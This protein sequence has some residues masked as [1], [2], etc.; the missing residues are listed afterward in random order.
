M[1][2][3]IVLNYYLEQYQTLGNTLTDL[4]FDNISFL[5]EQEPVYNE[6]GQ[7]VSKSYYS[8]EGKEAVRIEYL[9]LYGQHVFEGE[10]F[11]NVFLGLQKIIQFLD[12]NGEIANTKRKQAYLFL[13][14]PVYEAEIVTGFTSRK[15]RDI[16]NQDSYNTHI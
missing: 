15:M 8:L 4:S 12:W 7:K 10:T 6:A 1:S 14:E 9:R 13:L 11:E 2:A 5:Q 16:L 3:Q